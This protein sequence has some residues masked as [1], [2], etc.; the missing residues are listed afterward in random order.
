VLCLI[1]LGMGFAL[2]K[3]S[4]GFTGA[5][6]KLIVDRDSSGV[7]AQIVMLIAAM[8]LFAPFLAAG[9]AFETPVG[10]AVAPVSLSMAF[11]A[12]LFGIGMQA[13]AGCASGTLFAVGGARLYAAI[14]LLFFCVGGFWGSLD[15]HWWVG[16]PSFGAISFGERLGFTTAVVMQIGALALILLILFLAGIRPSSMAAPTGF[17]SWRG[18]LFGRWPLVFSGLLLALF[19]WLTLIIAGHPWSI[20]W[21]FALWVAKTLVLLGWD[22]STSSFWSG[23]FQQQALSQSVLHDTTS[24]TNFGIIL[25]AMIAASLAGSIRWSAPL[26][27]RRLL[28]AVGGGLAMGYGARLAYGCNIGAFFSGIASTSLH[29]WVWIICALPGNW[30]GIKLTSRLSR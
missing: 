18:L 7:V 25:G 19:N 11:G 1:G 16:L 17:F 6:R 22:P 24:V 21:G 14:T 28:L 5:Y 30:L 10:G 3:A 29:G 9:E 27:L 20:T 2:Y 26:Q 23:G 13:G 8:I 12:F 4:F 15:L